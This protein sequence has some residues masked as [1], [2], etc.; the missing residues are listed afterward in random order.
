MSLHR[1]Q[2]I[3]CPKCG[4]PFEAT[5]WQT[6]DTEL[7][8]DIAVQLISGELFRQSCPACG[9]TVTLSYP[10]LYHDRGRKAIVWVAP[11]DAQRDK[12]LA[13]MRQSMALPGHTTRLVADQ[14]QL[15]EKISA[16]EAGRDDRVLELLKW[17]LVQNLQQQMPDFKL[18]E[19]LY[20]YLDGEEAFHFFST[21]GRALHTPLEQQQYDFVAEKFAPQL[22]TLENATYPEV[23]FL[24]ASTVWASAT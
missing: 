14:D 13:V 8:E 5:I 1:T 15:R 21:D 6:V 23:N 12:K 24:W 10:L 20:L 7:G 17:L 3:P 9:H 11:A 18:R 16:L 2:T 4:K 22:K 19:V